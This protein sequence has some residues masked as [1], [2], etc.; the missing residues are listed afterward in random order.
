MGGASDRSPGGAFAGSSQGA[1]HPDST[2][3]D[4]REVPD[5]RLSQTDLCSQAD[6]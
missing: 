2:F 1:Y 5:R 3:A 4:P 6:L